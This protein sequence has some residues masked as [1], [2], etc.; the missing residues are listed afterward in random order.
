[1]PADPHQDDDVSFD[2][3]VIRHLEGCCTG[4]ERL[5]LER[6]LRNDP[7]RRARF[8]RLALQ[9]GQLRELLVCDHLVKEQ[10]LTPKR[11]TVMRRAPT[12]GSTRYVLAAAALLAAATILFLTMRTTAAPHITVA[13]G[14]GTLTRSG[15]SVLVGAGSWL[16][17]GDRV[18]LGA[19]ERLDLRCPDGSTLMLSPASELVLTCLDATSTGVSMRLE[20]G[21]IEAEVAPQPFNHPLVISTDQGQATVIGTHFTLSCD[22]ESA[23]LAVEKGAVRFN[24]PSGDL[25]LVNA[26]FI[27]QAHEGRPLSVH[28][29]GTLETPSAAALGTGL[30]GDY[31]DSLEFRDYRFSRVDPEIDFNW[32]PRAPDPRIEPET[33]SIRWTGEIAARTSGDYTFWVTVDDGVRLWIDGKL[34]INE[35]HRNEATEFS[36]H[37]SM[38]AGKRVPITL[39]YYQDPNVARVSLSWSAD[40]VAKHIVPRDCLFPAP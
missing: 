19:A 24:R 20:R 25:V 32:G 14:S 36:G 40:K 3:L 23:R 29:I 38:E 6:S 10:V 8:S 2:V 18:A 5:E 33:F 39:E 12:I 21:L 17:A 30:K 34:L 27:A 15:R 4:R 26:G 22:A 28:H 16:N 1:M 11:R 9:H 35:W 7:A 31:Y 13:N 37:I